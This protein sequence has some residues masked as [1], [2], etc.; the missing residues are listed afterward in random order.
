MAD[1]NGDGKPDLVEPLLNGIDAFSV[2]LNTTAA[3]AATPSFGGRVDF[4]RACGQAG[5]PTSI[6][7]DDINGDGKPD[8]IIACSD[9]STPQRGV[10]SVFLN[11]TTGVAG[12]PSFTAA[13]NV[14][15]LFSTTRLGVPAFF[16]PSLFFGEHI[17]D[18]Q[19]QYSSDLVLRNKRYGEI[20]ASPAVQPP[21]RP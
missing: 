19:L 2:V 9:P 18:R 12:P 21:A 8:V 4:T 7:A 1:F 15:E 14:V 16:Y 20:G 3:G 10:V 17:P 5:A 6:T 13:L 11:T